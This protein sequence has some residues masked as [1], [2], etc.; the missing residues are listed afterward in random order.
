MKDLVTLTCNKERHLLLLQ[1]ES[2]Q[3]FLEPCIHWIVVNEKNVNIES[4]EEIL[5]PFYDKHELQILTQ[6][7]LFENKENIHGFNT[8]QVC[9]LAIAKLIKDDYLILDSKNLFIKPTSIK[10]WDDIIGSGIIE[11]IDEPPE[12]YEKYQPYRRGNDK[13]WTNAIAQ[14]K[15]MLNVEPSYFLMPITPFKIEYDILEKSNLL[16]DIFYKLLFVDNKIVRY[17]ASEF[18]LYSFLANHKIIPGKN[19]IID[20]SSIKSSTLSHLHFEW[21][22]KDIVT[23]EHFNTKM[24]NLNLKVLG[25]HRN[26]LKKCGP[27]HIKVINKY[28]KKLEFNF[29]FI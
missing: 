16:D 4:W 14:Y 3:K 18:I 22:V 1:A 7:M 24:S 17:G 9:K 27:E 5:N 26:F 13:A 23:F 20:H 10:E 12:D 6:E 8:Q 15:N 28:L 29:Q 11:F 21:Y 25:I 19:T 2:I